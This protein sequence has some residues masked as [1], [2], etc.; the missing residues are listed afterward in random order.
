MTRCE[1]RSLRRLCRLGVPALVFW[2]VSSPSAAQNPAL[3]IGNQVRLSAPDFPEL[4]GTVAGAPSAEG[5]SLTVSNKFAP[6]VIPWSSIT[7]LAVNQPRSRGQGA[8]RGAMWGAG[9][10][11]GI[12]LI[13]LAAPAGPE[14]DSLAPTPFDGFVTG[15]TLGALIGRLRPGSRWRAVDVAAA[16][17]SAANGA[18]AADPEPQPRRAALESARK[19][20][21]P[22]AELTFGANFPQ[23][24]HAQFPG[25]IAS[26]A[27][28]GLRRPRYGAALVGELDASYLRF[29]SMLGPRIYARSGPLFANR[30]TLT[31]FG[32]FL[33]GKVA[34]EESGVLRS[35][36]GFAT[37]PGVGIDWGRNAYAL[38]VEFDYRNVP[39]SFVEDSRNSPP[40]IGDLSGERIAVGYTMRLG[41]R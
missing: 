32:Q 35:G 26:L 34:G 21:T 13:F 4:K 10:G 6:L 5:L 11:A 15:V 20:T 3:K 7:S 18:L 12:A 17:N 33:V 29:G 14:E 28:N 2:V 27:L 9:L 37:Q 24:Q 40:R 22:L 36:G 30:W 16:R 19:G 8:L 41:T 38:R 1:M 25:L 39:G 23:L 31:Y